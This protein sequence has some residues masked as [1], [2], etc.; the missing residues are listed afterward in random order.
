[1]ETKGGNWLEIKTGLI[2]KAISGFYYVLAEGQSYECKAKGAFRNENKSPLVGDYVEIEITPNEELKGTVS[3]ILDRR[4]TFTRPPFANLDNMFIVVSIVKPSPNLL[5]IDKLLTICEY[6][7]INPV[8]VI[9]KTDLT[10]ED[11]ID[12]LEQIYKKACYDV[13]KLNNV[14]PENLEEIKAKMKPYIKDSVSGFAGN[15]GVG[16]SSLIN[17]IAPNL[18]LATGVISQKLGRGKHTTRHV[19]LYYLDEFEGYVADTP[20][21]GSVEVMQYDV[22]MKDKLELCFR[23]F[24][25]YLDKCKF[26]DCA[27]L[28]EKGCAIVEAVANGDIAKQR[29]ENYVTLYNEAQKIKSWEH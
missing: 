8:I 13:I 16:K 12:N 20:G 23:E 25:P 4:N 11:V 14:E 17:N 7:D 28:C 18:E 6:K 24:E 29:H 22:I 1:M 2:Y 26:N 10:S 21:F 15:T 9:T 5:T 3:T 27:H 19:Q